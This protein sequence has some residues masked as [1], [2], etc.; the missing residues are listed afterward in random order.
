MTAKLAIQMLT[1]EY[2]KNTPLSLINPR[3][4]L[5]EHEKSRLVEH[6]HLASFPTE[7]TWSPE[8]VP[9]DNS[10]EVRVSYCWT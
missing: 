9:N 10:A 1:D 2:L 8:N 6:L 7:V 4:M 3:E 5:G